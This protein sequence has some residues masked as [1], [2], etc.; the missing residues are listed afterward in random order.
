MRSYYSLNQSSV[1]LQDLGLSRMKLLD[2]HEQFRELF[3][4]INMTFNHHILL[5]LTDTVFNWGPIWAHS[6][7]PFEACNYNI[8]RSVTSS[9]GRALQIVTR[10]LLSRF[11]KLSMDSDLITVDTKRFI[12][13]LFKKYPDTHRTDN[14]VNIGFCRRIHLDELGLNVLH[15]AG[16][17]HINNVTEYEK[18]MKSYFVNRTYVSMSSKKL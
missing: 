11:V 6:A 15:E 3:G 18:V 12:K 1:T 2:F 14:F 10:F 9:N 4:K 13:N 8:T 7:F 16:Y 17:N 5:H